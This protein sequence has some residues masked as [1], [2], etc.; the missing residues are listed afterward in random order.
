VRIANSASGVNQPDA[1]GL[2][3]DL[4]GLVETLRGHIRHGLVIRAAITATSQRLVS[5]RLSW[6]RS[7]K[8]ASLTAFGAENPIPFAV[9]TFLGVA[10]GCAQKAS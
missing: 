9:V 3:A 10:L 1:C 2:D 6:E 4:R 8:G 5:E 7:Q